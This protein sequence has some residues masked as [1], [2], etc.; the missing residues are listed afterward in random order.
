LVS[1]GIKNKSGQDNLAGLSIEKDENWNI[2][3]HQ[4]R[5]KE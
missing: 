4:T 2:E 1:A 3:S 5:Q